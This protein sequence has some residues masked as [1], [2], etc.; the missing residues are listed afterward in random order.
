MKKVIVLTISSLILT[1]CSA[2]T[3]PPS[4]LED[5]AYIEEHQLAEYVEMRN[6]YISEDM[7]ETID[8]I[9]SLRDKYKDSSIENDFYS[10]YIDIYDQDSEY[11]SIQDTF[12]LDN[13]HGDYSKEYFQD[14][15]E[16]LDKN[17]S[18]GLKDYIKKAYNMDL[19]L[20]AQVIKKIGRSVVYLENRGGDE[21]NYIS[22][23]TKLTNIKDEGYR[24]LFQNISRG[25]YI[26]DKIYTE[27]QLEDEVSNPLSRDLIS[28]V[29]KELLTYDENPKSVKIRYEILLE[30]KE[31]NK[32]NI[33]LSR[34]DSEKPKKEDVEVFINLLNTLDLGEED[35]GR[36]LKVYRSIFKEKID[37]SGLNI[38]GYS[39]LVKENKGN[40]YI[41]DNR[42]NVYIS[43]EKQ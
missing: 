19:S 11:G 4:Y 5:A 34:I 28:F 22:I 24:D 31:I 37:L 25:Q 39:V 9:N 23:R 15:V 21:G 8:E 17:Q 20:N 29:N 18:V 2:N 35:R 33:L 41:G 40:N 42:E 38:E 32:V 7:K 27:G 36:L 1:S 3:A 16:I 30:D 14:V 13:F 43:I 10:M 12:I 6:T 26:L